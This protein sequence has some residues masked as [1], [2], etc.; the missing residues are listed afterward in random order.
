MALNLEI[1]M[2]IL[3]MRE[4]DKV[5]IPQPLEKLDQTI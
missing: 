5:T 4:R 2:R 3:Q 1:R